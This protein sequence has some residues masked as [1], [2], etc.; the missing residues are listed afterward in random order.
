MPRWMAVAGE[1][2]ISSINEDDGDATGDAD[3][4]EMGEQWTTLIR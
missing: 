3:E 4:P 2:I 1:L